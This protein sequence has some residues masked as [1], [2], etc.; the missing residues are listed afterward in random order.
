[1]TAGPGAAA[2]N[3]PAAAW[4]RTRSKSVIVII[5]AYAA[6][7]GGLEAVMPAA[8]H[9]MWIKSLDPKSPDFQFND[10]TVVATTD[11]VEDCDAIDPSFLLD[12]TDGRLWLTLR[13]VFRIHPSCRT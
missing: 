2:R 7:G 13:D 11:G 3:D 4:P 12:P 5:L 1:M 10:N 8:I 9:V 6:G